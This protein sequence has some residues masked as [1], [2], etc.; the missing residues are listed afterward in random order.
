MPRLLSPDDACIRV[1]VPTGNGYE[2]R[3]DGRIIDVAD[4]VHVRMLKQEGYVEADVM[5]GPSSARGYACECG[6]SS[7]FRKCGRCGRTNEKE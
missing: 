5:G 7:Y 6:F 3:Y 4:P 2:R 1:K